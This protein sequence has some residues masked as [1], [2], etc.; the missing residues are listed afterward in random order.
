MILPVIDDLDFLN[1]SYK[2]VGYLQK[3]ICY[4]SLYDSTMSIQKV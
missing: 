1:L 4:S 3:V 2:T